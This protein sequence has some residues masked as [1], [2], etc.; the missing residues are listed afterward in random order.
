MQLSGLTSDLDK[1]WPSLACNGLNNSQLWAR[2]WVTH[3]TCG[4]PVFDQRDYFGTA[5]NFAKEVNLLEALT[6]KCKYFFTNEPYFVSKQISQD[7]LRYVLICYIDQLLLAIGW[8][9]S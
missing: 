1:H 8:T 3:G 4:E 6:N 5:I 7:C 9:T 2:E